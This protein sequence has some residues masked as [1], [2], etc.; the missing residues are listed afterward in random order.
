MISWRG[1]SPRHCARVTRLLSKK[2]RSGGKPLATLCSIWPALDLNLRPSA[3]E[4]NALP[5]NQLAGQIAYVF[6]KSSKFKRMVKTVF[7][8]WKSNLSH[9]IRSRNMQ[10]RRH[11]G[12]F[13]G[14][15]PQITA[16]A[17]LNENWAPLKRGL[18]PKGSYWLGAT[19]MQFEAWGSQNTGCYPRTREQELFFRRFCKKTLFLW[20]QPR[21]RDNSRIFWDED[22]FFGL[23]PKSCGK[24]LCFWSTLSNLKRWTF[25]ATPKFVYA[26][27]IQSRCPGAGPGNMAEAYANWD[28]QSDK[29]RP[30]SQ[31]KFNAAMLPQPNFFPYSQNIFFK[32]IQLRIYHCT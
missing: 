29:A 31:S 7:V 5:L 13:R 26:P 3:P 19:A 28:L 14:H 18:C 10:A 15:A 20:F 8:L 30:K 23:H 1:P 16:C 2:C 11:G 17:P 22:F 32:A 4:T 24:D 12:A 9:Q 21:N 25:C 6:A 27:P